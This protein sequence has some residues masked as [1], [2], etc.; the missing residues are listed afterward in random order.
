MI[1]FLHV[2]VCF[3]F[4]FF[5]MER[6]FVCF[7]HK[8]MKNTAYSRSGNVRAPGGDA[9]TSRPRRKRRAGEENGGEVL[10]P[11]EVQPPYTTKVVRQGN[12]TEKGDEAATAAMESR[13]RWA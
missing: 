12:L 11:Y 1:I 9:N 4:E 5:Y 8:K 6:Q 2:C 7:F 13:E 10:R 3:F